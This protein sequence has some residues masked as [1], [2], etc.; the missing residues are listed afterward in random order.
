MLEW[1]IAVGVDLPD[2]GE[3]QSI[4]GRIQ[5]AQVL[6]QESR[7]HGNDSLHEVDTCGAFRGVLVDERV[8]ANEVAHVGDVHAHFV[9]AVAKFCHV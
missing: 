2:N 9:E 5:T 7:Q 4:S 6:T 3:S 8:L 1:Y